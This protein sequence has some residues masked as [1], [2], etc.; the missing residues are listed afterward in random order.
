MIS[1]YD[2]VAE[3]GPNAVCAVVISIVRLTDIL[4]SSLLV[5][6]FEQFWD[7]WGCLAL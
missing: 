5:L 6:Q 3:A 2:M 7:S 1:Q 4:S